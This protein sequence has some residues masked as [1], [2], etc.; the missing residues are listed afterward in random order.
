LSFQKQHDTAKKGE[1]EDPDTHRITRKAGPRGGSEFNANRGSGFHANQQVTTSLAGSDAGN[2]VLSSGSQNDT[3]H[4]TADITKRAITG[5]AAAQDKVYD[6]TNHADLTNVAL[7][8]TRI[9]AGDNLS[10]SGNTGS[11]SDKNVG[12]GKSVVGSGLSLAGADAQNYDLTTTVTGA[13]I[14]PKTITASATAENK[15]YDATTTATIGAI[16]LNGIINGD[17]IDS[18]ATG[19]TFADKNAGTG[20]VVH[21]TGLGLTGNDANNYVLANDEVA[22]ANIDRKVITATANAKDKTYDGNVTADLSNVKLVGIIGQDVVAADGTTGK[23]DTKNVG[24][25]KSVNG[26]GLSLVGDDSGNYVLDTKHAV[27][28]ADITPKSITVTAAASDKVYDGNTVAVLSHAYAN[29]VVAGDD[30]R[31]AGTV[32]TFSDKN[33]GKGKSVNGS[34]LTLAGEDAQ[35]YVFDNT[36]EVGKA[37]I[38]PKT[39]E[40]SAKAD[41]KVYD[42]NTIAHLS[43]VKLSGLVDGDDIRAEGS[44]GDFD[45]R[46]AGRNKSVNG[47]GLVLTG[48]DA[49]NYSLDTSKEVAKADITPKVIT[50]TGSA[51]DK[52]Y[53]GKTVAAVGD[54]ALHGVVAGDK[55]AIVGDTGSFDNSNAGT[56]KPVNGEGLSL[57]GADAG[58][59]ILDTSAVVAQAD[60]RP[61]YTPSALV[62]DATGANG[63]A[64]ATK[65]AGKV[66]GDQVVARTEAPALIVGLPVT[67]AQRGDAIDIADGALSTSVLRMDGKASLG[68]NDAREER[69]QRNTLVVFR[70]DRPEALDNR[71]TFHVVDRGNAI[72]L[73]G[74]PTLTNKTPDLKGKGSD[75]KNG[76]VVRADG[77]VTEYRVRILNDGTLVVIVPNGVDDSDEIAASYGLAVAKKQLGIGVKAVKAVV[78]E[79]RN[80]K[81]TSN[82]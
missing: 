36:A 80:G 43:D 56:N 79:A 33:A 81:G 13:S 52:S 67:P 3:L 65:D 21:A 1:K 25:S 22:H 57:A 62:A 73:E 7:D 64:Q 58:N 37:A 54:L 82:A 39:I 32:G 71:G 14:T 51:K 75:W 18:T 26:E 17:N 4:L 12:T 16:T 47:S 31:V 70:S 5:T 78:I 53:D 44:N 28:T 76:T 41:N 61:A 11:F 50:A 66:V 24:K 69:E 20:K 29:D 63:T 68:L 74:T 23:F 27:A 42:G 10:I 72:E 60:V 45:N 6:G 2:Y 40:A 19:A 30:L 55:V 38:T 9:V 48:N 46:N 8:T 77:A 59:Y 35:N 34:G 49:N 15:V